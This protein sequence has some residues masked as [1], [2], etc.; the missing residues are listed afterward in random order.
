MKE[1][2]VL[3]IQNLKACVNEFEVLHNIN[4]QIKTNE[5]HVIMGPN[6]SGKSSLLKVIAGHPSYKVIEGKIFVEN[7]D[8]TQATPEE[9]SNLGVFLGFQYPIEITGVN[10]ADFLRAVYNQKRKKQGLKDLD[11]LEFLE[12]LSPIL[13]LVS[14]D[15]TFLH[16]NLNEGFSGGEKKRNEILQM[17][18]SKPRLA[19]LDEPDSGLDIDALRSISEVINKLRNQKQCMLIIT[20]YQNLLDYVIPDKVHIMD[21]G[22]IVETGDVTLAIQLKRKGYKWI[23]QSTN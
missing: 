4:L 7:I 5:T 17:I 8:I 9:R 19:I 3:T 6:G 16:R 20:H 18:L 15:Q 10:N 21:H 13:D 1:T 23:K 22:K 12:I 14:M 2:S 11:P